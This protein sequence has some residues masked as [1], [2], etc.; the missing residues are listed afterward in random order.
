MGEV[1]VK[2]EPDGLLSEQYSPKCPNSKNLIEEAYPSPSANGTIKFRSGDETPDAMQASHLLF[3][4]KES[5][6][7]EGHADCF[8]QRG[9]QI[10]RRGSSLHHF[11]CN[12]DGLEK[13]QV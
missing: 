3:S 4:S 2:P 6:G 12:S 5:H 11:Q 13:K 7:I 10:R 9:S 1:A 8:G